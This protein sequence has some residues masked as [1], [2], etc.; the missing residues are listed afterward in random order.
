[1]ARKKLTIRKAIDPV[2]VQVT[3]SVKRPKSLKITYALLQQVVQHWLDTGEVV[4]GF[5]ID[6]IHWYH[7]E[8]GLDSVHGAT[9][10]QRERVRRLV[11]RGKAGVSDIRISRGTGKSY[12]HTM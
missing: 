10:E 6:G 3:V 5:S 2:Q 8:T 1:M 11:R 9:D 7:P 4:R 12:A